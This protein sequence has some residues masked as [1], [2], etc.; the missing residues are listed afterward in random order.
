MINDHWAWSDK[1]VLHD[2]IDKAE[3]KAAVFASIQISLLLVENFYTIG[4]CDKYHILSFDS[5]FPIFQLSGEILQK[6]G[7]TDVGAGGDNNLHQLH[8]SV[9]IISTTKN[10]FHHER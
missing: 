10:N 8:S 2:K 4:G 7:E 6:G 1:K 5:P 9:K 3:P